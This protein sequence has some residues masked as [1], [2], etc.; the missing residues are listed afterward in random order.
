[1]NFKLYYPVKPLHVNQAFG[2]NGEYYRKNGIN[3]DGHNGLDLMASHGQPVYASHDGL[4]YPGVDDKEGNGVVIRTTSQFDYK[5]NPAFFKTIY[6]HFLGAPVVKTGQKVSAGDLLGYADS[7]G[8]STG[9]HLHFGLKPQLPGEPDEVWINI[10]QGN[11]YL[12]A[13]DPTPYFNGEFAQDLKSVFLNDMELGE[14]NDDIRRLQDKLKRLNYF[15]KDQESTGYYGSVTRGAVY[16]FQLDYVP[17]GWWAKYIYRGRYC[18]SATRDV[19][20]KL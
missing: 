12:G 5:G 16:K 13:I 11:G 7:S 6:W 20:N 1:M 4:A 2:V 10:E 17:M 3:I 15:P 14:T 9:D 8:L 18:Y 19:L